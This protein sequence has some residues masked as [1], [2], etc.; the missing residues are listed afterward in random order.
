MSRG[1]ARSTMKIGR[2]WRAL[3]ALSTAPRPMMGSW[4]AVQLI[5][6]VKFVQPLGQVR[7]PHYRAAKAR[8]QLLAALQACGWPQPWRRG[9][10]RQSASRQFDHFARAD[11]QDLNVR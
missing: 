8:R 9:F 5:T 2:R 3:S 7:Q 10:W 1:T 11:E 6:R 4:L